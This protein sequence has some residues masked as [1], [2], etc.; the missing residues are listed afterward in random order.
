ME[1]ESEVERR[2]CAVALVGE[3]IPIAEVARRLGRSRWWVYEWLGR[4]RR[5]GDEGLIA[6]STAPRQRPTKTSTS[7]VGKILDTRRRLVDQPEAS[8]GAWSILAQLERD[9]WPDIPSIA[10]IERILADAR[11]TRRRRKRDRSNEEKLPLPTVTSPGI[12]QQTDW[13]QDRYLTGG[14]RF[15]SIQTSDVGSHAIASGQF[16]DRSMVSA[17]TFLLEQAWPTLSIPQAMSVDNAFAHTTHPNNPFTA[18]IRACLLFGVE[19]IIGPPG[20]HG[21]TNHIEA[22]NYLW[23]QRTIWAQRFNNLDDLRAGSRRA[24][25]WLNT[26]RPILD[27]DHYGTR[28]PAEYINTHTDTLKW[29]PDITVADHL[30]TRGSLTLPLAKGRITFIRHVTDHNTITIADTHWPIPPTISHGK[31]VIAT[32]TTDNNSLEI[33]HKGEHVTTHP[34]PITHPTIDPHYPPH[35]TSLLNHV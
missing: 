15:N 17:V 16:L 24:V 27:P 7:T 29:P 11:V 12:W 23:Q 33:R 2:R 32:L 8:I 5:S 19:A 22:V 20:R 26:C 30:N 28:Y 25:D 4:Y 18:W 9:Q 14:L 35:T 31:A 21:W 13:V 6:R 34:Y 10:T 3:G 1:F